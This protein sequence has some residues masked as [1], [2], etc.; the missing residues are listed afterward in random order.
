M[1]TPIVPAM[2]PTVPAT[3]LVYLDVLR[4]LAVLIM[5]FAHVVD[6]W[7]READRHDFSYYA[8]IFVGGL[9]A[10]LFLFL[11]G[12]A[13]VMSANAK[14]RRA[15]DRRA[16]AEAMWRRGWEVFVLAWLFRLQSQLL[17]WGALRNLFK[18]DILNVMGVSM[19][20]AALLWRVSASRVVRVGVLLA[21][22]AVVS[23]ATPIVR[24]L[25]WP[26]ALPDPLEAYIRPA[27]G[28]AAFTMFPWAGFLFAGAIVGELVDA[29]RTARVGLRLQVPLALAGLLGIGLGWW[30]SLR[31]SIYVASG[32]W[33]SSPTFF[34]IRLG[35][36]TTLVPAAW[37]HCE[38]WLRNRSSGGH[39]VSGAGITRAVE[40]LGRSSLFVYWIHVEM[41]YGVI[42]TPLKRSLPL[43]ASLVATLTLCV[44]LFYIVRL[45]NRRMEGVELPERW[46]IFA[47]VLR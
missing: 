45:K 47:A 34:F 5:V 30:A 29:M 12:L 7:T 31:P 6:S 33:T 41:V 8:A 27:G 38:F 18:V 16:G 13:Q 43:W 22:T 10:P 20:V 9:G 19:V 37:A 39:R 32:F 46:K 21:A 36:C 1:T 28:Y 42:A 24:A 35:L 17:G 11:A 40:L 44:A 14:A 4:G 26:A 25:A 2:P 23:F 15:G 3:R